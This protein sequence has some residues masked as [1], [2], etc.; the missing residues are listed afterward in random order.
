MLLLDFKAIK[1]EA[2]TLWIKYVIAEAMSSHIKNN[3][4]RCDSILT[5]EKSLIKE[6]LENSFQ[7]LAISIKGE[8]GKKIREGIKVETEKIDR[9]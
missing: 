6:E 3:Y 2:E 8:F 7:N 5:E 9:L 1:K 4:K